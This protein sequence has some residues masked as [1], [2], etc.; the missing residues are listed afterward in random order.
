MQLVRDLCNDNH[1]VWFSWGRVGESG[2]INLIPYQKD[3]LK[4]QLL[5]ER[6]FYSKT[7]NWW[8]VWAKDRKLEKR[9]GKY[10][11]LKMDYSG[12]KTQ[13]E[14]IQQL[15]EDIA[16]N[17]ASSRLKP[18]LLKLM[19]LIF[20]LEEM[21][22]TV[23]DMKFDLVKLPLGMLT[24]EQILT[25]YKALHKIEDCI[26]RESDKSEL[27]EACSEFYTCIPHS[28]LRRERPT[29]ICTDLL[30]QQKMEL[31]EIIQTFLEKTH[32]ETY[33]NYHLELQNVFLIEKMSCNESFISVGN[34]RMLWHG[35]KNRN[36]AGILS[37][38]LCIAPRAEPANGDMFE[39]GVY[40]ADCVSKSA[41]YCFR[42][43]QEEG[44]MLLCEVSLGNTKQ[45]ANAKSYDTLP[46]GEK[47]DYSIT[48][49]LART[50][51]LVLHSQSNGVM[52]ACGKL[53]KQDRSDL[54]LLYNEY[55]VYN[56][57][58]VKLVYLVK[59]KFVENDAR[60]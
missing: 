54:S 17:F 9:K 20:D 45:E 14:N 3:I 18:N 48:L 38:G 27:V 51:W 49:N 28:F 29:L 7:G 32:G 12:S 30:V 21:R 50:K 56:I 31:L 57:N 41:N 43:P 33:T 47:E 5:F 24:K 44:L 34:H 52:M 15:Y 2:S 40:F 36:F 19:S 42:Q 59:V 58:Q 60:E 22:E 13:E 39:K 4:V 26:K 35:S 16:N 46:R 8:E 55:I 11:M 1:Y 25:G 37:R 6:S 10:D 53:V 23:V